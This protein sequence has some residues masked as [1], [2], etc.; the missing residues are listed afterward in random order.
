MI[1]FKIGI[2]FFKCSFKLNLKIYFTKKYKFIFIMYVM[3]SSG[4]KLRFWLFPLK[5]Y[6]IL[7]S[8]NDFLVFQIEL[9]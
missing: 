2:F 6:A 1:L 8:I 5:L 9:F 4:I 7:G 3:S